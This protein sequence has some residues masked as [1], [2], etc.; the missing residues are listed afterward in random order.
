MSF[1]FGSV[2]LCSCSTPREPSSQ[3]ISIFKT[4]RHFRK[5]PPHHTRVGGFSCLSVHCLRSLRAL[6][7]P[8][9]GRSCL[10]GDGVLL[11]VEDVIGFCL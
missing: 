9:Y 5:G 1:A 10:T 7:N 4:G 6:V 8:H 2:T 3:S 11:L